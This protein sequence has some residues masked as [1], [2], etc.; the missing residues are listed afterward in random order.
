MNDTNYTGTLKILDNGEGYTW[1]VKAF[2][3]WK[4]KMFWEYLKQYGRKFKDDFPTKHQREII[5]K[6]LLGFTNI[7]IFWTGRD[8]YDIPISQELY[9]NAKRVSEI[10]AK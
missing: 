6:K 10:I 7:D 8:I 2:T 4:E 1:S 9:K 5:Y 3:Q